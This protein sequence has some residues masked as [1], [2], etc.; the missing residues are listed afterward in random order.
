MEDF[1][2]NTV[3]TFQHGSTTSQVCWRT[4]RSDDKPCQ[5]SN[6]IWQPEDVLVSF[7]HPMQRMVHCT[8]SNKQ[9]KACSIGSGLKIK[10]MEMTETTLEPYLENG[11]IHL[12]QRCRSVLESVPGRSRASRRSPVFRASAV[13]CQ[14]CLVYSAGMLYTSNNDSTRS[15]PSGLSRRVECGGRIGPDGYG[16][17]EARPRTAQRHRCS[18]MGACD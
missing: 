6:R 8:I 17:K 16:S 12:D 11:I 14:F 15:C 3:R 13:Q 9:P 5:A 18:R 1:D 2:G 7:Y 4:D 10:E